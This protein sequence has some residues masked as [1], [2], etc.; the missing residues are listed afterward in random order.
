MRRKTILCEF[1]A[2]LC[3]RLCCSA[4]VHATDLGAAL[5]FPKV[6]SLNSG[7][8]EFYH[9]SR[10]RRYLRNIRGSNCTCGQRRYMR[11][12]NSQHL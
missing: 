5:E 7:T 1:T 8:M 3:M 9:Q 11:G 4:S 12:A 2:P 6:T 10:G